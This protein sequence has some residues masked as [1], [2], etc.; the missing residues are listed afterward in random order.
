MLFW[1]SLHLKV[2]AVG[3]IIIQDLQEHVKFALGLQMSYDN[4]YVAD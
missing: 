3:H 2:V 4:N 1:G